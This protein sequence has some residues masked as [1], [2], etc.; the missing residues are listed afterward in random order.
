MQG[1]S[2]PSE[3]ILLYSYAGPAVTSVSSS[4]GPVQGGLRLTVF[5]SGYGFTDGKKFVIPP[6]LGKFLL[7]T[8]D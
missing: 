7:R 5:G 2:A 1:I 3:R 4:L 8:Y 6:V